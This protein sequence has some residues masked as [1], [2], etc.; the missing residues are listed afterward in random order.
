VPKTAAIK[1]IPLIWVF[2]YKFDTDGYLS[3]FKA[4]LCVRGDLQQP[5]HQDTY[6]A[7]LAAKA[8]RALMAIVAAFDLEAWQFDAINAFT[9]SQIDETIYCDYPEGFEQP[10]CC[11]LLLQALYGLRRSPL[12]WLKEFSRT[13]TDLG[14]TQVGEEACIFTNKWLTVFFYVDDIVAICQTKDLPK[15]HQFKEALMDRYELRDMGPLN[16]FLGIRILRDRQQRKL[17]LCQDSYIEK[18]ARTFHLEHVKPPSTPMATQ[19]ELVPYD[20]KASPQEIYT[21]QQK[22]GSLLYATIITRP[23]VAHTASRLSKYLQNPS[24]Q[25][26]GAATSSSTTSSPAACARSRSARC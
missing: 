8:F 15:L 2:T 26:Q 17:W 24:P 18:I 22:V 11:L 14:L 13:L 19:Q 3:K 16:W 23:D 9:N 20:G 1:T 7:T 6:A 21:Y 4:R 10:G 12:L 5:I 25:H